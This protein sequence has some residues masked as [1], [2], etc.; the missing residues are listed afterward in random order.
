MVKVEL[1]CGIDHLMYDKFKTI[2]AGVHVN[3][4]EILK[5]LKKG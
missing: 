4:N 3:L 2:K 5:G 1:E